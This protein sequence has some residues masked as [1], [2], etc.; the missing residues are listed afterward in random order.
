MRNIL[1]SNFFVR[2]LIHQ[3]TTKHQNTMKTL[4]NNTNRK[5]KSIEVN[6]SNM[7]FIIQAYSHYI[8][9]TTSNWSKTQY[10]A[11]IKETGEGIGAMGSR[12]LIKRQMQLINSRPELFIK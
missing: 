3:T 8:Y 9:S 2:Y 6:F 4:V 12:D 10:T 1:E 5:V 7:T 11:I